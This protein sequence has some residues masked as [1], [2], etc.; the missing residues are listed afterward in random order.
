MNSC[1]EN[2]TQEISII[3]KSSRRQMSLNTTIK[4]SIDQLELNNASTRH[5]HFSWVFTKQSKLHKMSDVY[6]KRN[7]NE[8]WKY[9]NKQL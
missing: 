8:S 1:E 5:S 4:S 9:H 2:K 7:S 3:S 6:I